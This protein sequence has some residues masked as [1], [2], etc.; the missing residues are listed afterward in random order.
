MGELKRVLFLIFFTCIIFMPVSAFAATQTMAANGTWAS[1]AGENSSNLANASAGDNVDLAGYNLTVTNNGIANDGSGLNAFNIGTISS[2]AVNGQISIQGT[3]NA[4]LNVTMASVTGGSNITNLSLQNSDGAAFNDTATVTGAFSAASVNVNNNQATSIDTTTQLNVEGNFTTTGTVTLT[5]GS[6]ESADAV[7][8]L[9]GSTIS[10]GGVILADGP[11]A[12]GYGMLWI[13]GSVDQTVTG[14]INGSA[15]EN[16]YLD[17]GID[18]NGNPTSNNITMESNIGSGQS[19]GI[20]NVDGSGT[21][22]FNGTVNSDLIQMA[23]GSNA[24]FNHNVTAVEL[25][26]NGGG[27]MTLANGADLTAQI[28]IGAIADLGTFII[29]GTSTLTGDVGEPSAPL[30]QISLTGSGA[31][32]TANTTNGVVTNNISLGTNKLNITGTYTQ[33][34][35]GVLATTIN[36]A[37]SY[38]RITATGNAAVPN[39]TTLDVAITGPLPSTAT[40]FNIVDGNGSP[41]VDV[42]GTVSVTGSN[43]TFTA[44]ISSGDLVLDLA[45]GGFTSSATNSNGQ[46]AATVLDKIAAT[47]TGDMANVITALDNL[48]PGAVNAAINSMLPLIGLNQQA[49]TQV[50]D[51]FVGTQMSHLNNAAEADKSQ[52]VDLT[53]MAAGDQPGTI[54]AWSQAFGTTAHQSPEGTSNGYDLEDAGGALGIEDALSDSYRMGIALGDS[55]S[56]IQSKDDNGRMDINAA[57]ISL[58]GGYKPQDNGLYL[59]YSASYAYNDYYGTRDVNAGP[60]ISREAKADYNGSLFGGTVEGGYGF[61]LGQA[62]VTPNVSLGY[63]YLYIP[64][65]SE[66]NAGALDL[67]VS[68]Q[69]YQRLRLAPGFKIEL[70]EEFSMG[71][72]TPEFHAKYL[73]DAISDKDQ[74]LAS[75]AGGGTAF[76]T[77]GYKPSDQGA[78]LGMS[79]TFAT[80][81]NISMS[82]QYDFEIREDY[83]SNTGLLNVSYR[84]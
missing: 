38:G 4:D 1:A 41:G 56:W 7:L 84:F 73:W 66:T 9:G 51:D 63:N 69:D 39:T 83:Y 21:V 48:S 28:N 80:K 13:G 43:R 74:I 37:N 62:V 57:Q 11:G 27:T 17:L 18:S 2:S 82:L 20:M 54:T 12:V 46:A 14:Q 30:N 81:N 5:G 23:A 15:A 53:G 79:I 29:Q 36:G 78:D 24:V 50:M 67:N 34:A 52:G 64:R 70:P 72:L 19:I 65:Y 60:T 10:T 44:M 22:T 47:A 16:G 75:F 8:S 77:A 33:L 61:N 59:D 40:T 3:T 76:T 31:T 35:G 26:F 42:P 45:A 68:R 58:Y 25:D 55:Y 71:T 49:S 6:A 32:V